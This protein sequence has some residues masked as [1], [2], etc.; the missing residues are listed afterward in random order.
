MATFITKGKVPFEGGFLEDQQ[1]LMRLWGF[2]VRDEHFYVGGVSY[3]RIPPGWKFTKEVDEDLRKYRLYGP[4]GELKIRSD[5][6][7]HEQHQVYCVSRLHKVYKKE[8]P[9]RCLG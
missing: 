6:Y 3:L 7:A 4:D 1:G 8:E 9:Q 5:L 2:D